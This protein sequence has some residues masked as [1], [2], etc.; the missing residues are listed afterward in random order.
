MA[1]HNHRAFYKLIRTLQEVMT[2]DRACVVDQNVHFPHLLTH[3]QCGGVHVLAFSHVTHI[4]V[5]LGLERGH[6]FYPSD[7]S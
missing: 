6:L 1:V 7:S 3:L 4:C 2:R 5:N